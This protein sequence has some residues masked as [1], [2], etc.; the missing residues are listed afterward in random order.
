M[1]DCTT[2]PKFTSRE[3]FLEQ[4][5]FASACNL[6]DPAGF[7]DSLRWPFMLLLLN[8]YFAW[9]KDVQIES[10]ILPSIQFILG[11]G[12]V[13]DEL[14]SV[15]FRHGAPNDSQMEATLRLLFQAASSRHQLVSKANANVPTCPSGH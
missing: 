4:C 12:P 8:H 15:L 2:V 3:Q 14:A 5:E 6:D 10:R 13:R 9:I 7:A 1:A 11:S